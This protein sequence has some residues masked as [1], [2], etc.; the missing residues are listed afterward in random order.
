MDGEGAGDEQPWRWWQ[1]LLHPIAS[2][3]DLVETFQS[4]A[5]STYKEIGCSIPPPRYLLPPSNFPLSLWMLLSRPPSLPSLIEG[6]RSN[7]WVF[8]GLAGIPRQLRSTS[9]CCWPSLLFRKPGGY[10]M[11]HP[12]DPLD[13]PPSKTF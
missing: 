12:L 13:P 5:D 2:Y 11:P 10:T 8:V 4:S 3:D 9:S 1:V 6:M 7:R